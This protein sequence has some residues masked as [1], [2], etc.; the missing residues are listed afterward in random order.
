MTRLL[1]IVLASALALPLGGC[2]NISD[3]LDPT[4]WFAGDLFNTKKKLPGE[5][6]PVFP[7]GVPGVAQGIPSD[8]VKGDQPPSSSYAGEPQVTAATPQA[9]AAPDQFRPAPRDEAKPKRKAKAKELTPERAPTSVTV[10]RPPD[11]QPQPPPQQQDQAAGQWPDP[12]PTRAVRPGA[13]QWPDPP[14]LR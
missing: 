7:Q 10:R 4:E 11:S 8:L 6:K 5:R 2:A 1:W 13:V 9:G 14:P 3:A 12:P